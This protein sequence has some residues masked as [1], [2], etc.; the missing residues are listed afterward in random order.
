MHGQQN[1]KIWYDI[2]VNC[3][4]VDTWWQM[5]DQM[6]V[7]ISVKCL[8]VLYNVQIKRTRNALLC[9]VITLWHPITSVFV[10]QSVWFKH[11]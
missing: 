8:Y 7:V 10:Q 2:F 6:T 1:I 3:S 5:I 4:W 11:W 9:R